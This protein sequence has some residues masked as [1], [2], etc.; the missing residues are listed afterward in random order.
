MKPLYYIIAFFFY[1]SF[2]INAHQEFYKRSANNQCELT[3]VTATYN[4]GSFITWQAYNNIAIAANWTQDFPS[5]L[6]VFTV[7]D[8][9][10]NA[11]SNWNLF[12]GKSLFLLQTSI[13]YNVRVTF[14]HDYNIFPLAGGI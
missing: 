13:G 1:W 6:N 11:V 10:N 2:F 14:I 9:F 8:Q 4:N 5:E 3:N 7:G 12:T